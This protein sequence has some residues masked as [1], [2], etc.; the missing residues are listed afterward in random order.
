MK[1]PVQPVRRN[2][3]AGVATCSTPS[4]LFGAEI[5]LKQEAGHGDDAVHRGAD[6]VAHVGQEFGFGAGGLLGGEAGGVQLLVGEVDLVLQALGAEGSAE[7]GAQLDQFE[8]LGDVIDRAQLEAAQLVGGAVPGV[9]TM[10]GIDWPSACIFSR[11]RTSK[12]SMPG[13]PR[14]SRMRSCFFA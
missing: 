14:S 4:A 7:P 5:G 13:R 6:F 11:R 9:R 8:E 10:T 1:E 12:P 2:A 3:D